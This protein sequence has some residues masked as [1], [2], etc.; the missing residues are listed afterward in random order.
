ME[1]KIIIINEYN[2]NGIIWRVDFEQLCSRFLYQTVLDLL[3]CEVKY[4]TANQLSF[5]FL[6]ATPP[7]KHSPVLFS[8]IVY[9][10]HIGFFATNTT[11]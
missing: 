11:E 8:S 7:T 4:N 10:R 6:H 9:Y 5:S 3:G 1:H 2:G